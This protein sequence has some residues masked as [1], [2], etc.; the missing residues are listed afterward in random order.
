MRNRIRVPVA[1]ARTAREILEVF[2]SEQ[3]SQD[4]L[5]LVTCGSVD[6]GKSTLLG[7]L[8]WESQV[9]ADD[10]L[11]SLKTD[12]KR[13]GTQGEAI[14]FALL[15][16]GLSAERE[17]GITIDVA[18]R[19]FSTSRRRFIVADAPGHEQYTRNMV[20]AASTAFSMPRRTAVGIAPEVTYFKP[21]R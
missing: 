11:E 2:G 12:S 19:F 3:G 15:F 10:Q 16:D 7:R 17:Q 20:T 9:L 4:L 21:S 18:H 14:D 8:L 6:D 1:Q 13:Y 5:R